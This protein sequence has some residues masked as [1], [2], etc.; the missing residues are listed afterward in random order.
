[1]RDREANLILV[2][3]PENKLF[4]GTITMRGADR[5]EDS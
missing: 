4:I 5:D 2:D 3:L 1:M